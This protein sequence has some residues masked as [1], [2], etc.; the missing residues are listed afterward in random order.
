MK[1]SYFL[2]LNYVIIKIEKIKFKFCL[3]YF[4]N[5]KDQKTKQVIFVIF[6]SFLLVYW[7][8]YSEKN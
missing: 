1:N 5:K 4:L 8:S 7:L 6:V 3:K 2:N